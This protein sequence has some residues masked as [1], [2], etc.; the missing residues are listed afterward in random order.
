MLAERVIEMRAVD[1]SRNVLRGWR[2][3]VGTDLLGGVTVTVLF[4]R[5]GTKGRALQRTVGGEAEAMRLLRRALA[6]R[7]T[8]ER[9]IG[10]GYQVVESWGLDESAGG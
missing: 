8:A 5:L 6:R 7:A 10:V 9:R 3:E 1:R 4:G 2:C